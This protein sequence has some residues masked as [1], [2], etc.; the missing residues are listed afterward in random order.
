MK[1][2]KTH[3]NPEELALAAENTIRHKELPL[4]ILNHLNKCDACKYELMTLIELQEVIIDDKTLI[5]KRNPVRWL[6][7]AAIIL[8]LLAVGVWWTMNLNSKQSQTEDQMVQ[9]SDP[10]DNSIEAINLKDEIV[11]EENEQTTPAKNDLLALAAFK[12]NPELERLT[13]RYKTEMRNAPNPAVQVESILDS[14]YFS[15]SVHG[16]LIFELYNNEG[17]L[18]EEIQTA[19]QKVSYEI[20]QPGLYYFKLINQDFDLLWCGKIETN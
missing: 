1:N 9:Q 16:L 17:V 8:V 10:K 15:W 13:E 3:L 19:S 2:V 6:A 7:V 11:V 12:P 20:E 5:L 4:A 18:L 14:L